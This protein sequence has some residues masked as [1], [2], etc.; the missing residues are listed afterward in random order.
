MAIESIDLLPIR[1]AFALRGRFRLATMM[2]TAIAAAQIKT[3]STMITTSIG[4]SES[5][6]ES[7]PVFLAS[8]VVT[9]DSGGTVG[10]VGDAVDGSTVGSKEGRTVGSI[11]GGADG[12]AVG[13]DGDTV[14]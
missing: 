13:A 5:S 9:M 14:G 7:A 8:N 3:K 6:I 11:E 4:V 10:A 2:N 1:C 12:D